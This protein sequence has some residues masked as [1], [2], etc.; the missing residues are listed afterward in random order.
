[1]KYRHPEYQYLDLL[2]DILD[3]GVKKVDRGTG[4]VSQSVFG[5]QIRF[6]LS[7]GFP[8][9]TTKKV[10][11]KGVLHELNW[12]MK[13]MLNI[14]YL[15]DNNVHIWDDYPYRIYVEKSKKKV[16][17][18]KYKELLSKEEFINNIAADEKFAKKWG[19]L[20]RIYGE[21]WRRWPCKSKDLQGKPRTIDQLKWVIQEIKE[22]PAAHN[23]IVNSWNPEYL[24]TM[25]LKKDASRFPICHNMYQINIIDGKLSLQLYQRSA[26]IFLGVPFNIASYALLALILAKV[27][28]YEPG[29]FIHTFGDVHIYELHVTQVQEQLK[30]KPKVFPTIHFNHSFKTVDD[31][32]PSYVD[33][34]GYNPHL[35]IKASLSV[36]GGLYDENL[37]LLKK[38]RA[39]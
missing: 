39:I 16:E 8:L 1:M 22:D 14:K 35:P 6:D 3:H 19:E 38:L 36:T 29:E 12:F 10:Y 28:G 17:S 11:W 23:L 21:M 32:E 37:K 5:R 24:Y 26:D 27:T 30:R 9:L 31:F 2:Q 33:L 13:G 25:A 34:V 15:V 20:P 18:I 4:D 7:Q